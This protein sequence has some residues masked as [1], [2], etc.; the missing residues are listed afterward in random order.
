MI[1]FPYNRT[2]MVSIIFGMLCSEFALFES[3]ETDWESRI[4]DIKNVIFRHENWI[5]YFF[6]ENLKLKHPSVWSCDNQKSDS[7]PNSLRVLWWTGWIPFFLLFLENAKTLFE[8]LEIRLEHFPSWS[9]RCDS[10]PSTT[11]KYSFYNV[12]NVFGFPSAFATKRKRT[13]SFVGNWSLFSDSW[14]AIAGK[15]NWKRNQFEQSNEL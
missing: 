15:A 2:L 4:S 9:I 8:F 10:V 3:N 12:T 5:W 7:F 1:L 6:L 13:R 11:N 14:F